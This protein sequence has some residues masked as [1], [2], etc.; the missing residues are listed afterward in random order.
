M[1]ESHRYYYLENKM[2]AESYKSWAKSYGQNVEII[3][4][5]LK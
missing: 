4:R 1:P 5:H 2:N 3:T